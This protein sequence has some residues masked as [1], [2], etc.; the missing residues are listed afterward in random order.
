MEADVDFDKR[1]DFF[2]G[3]LATNVEQDC[4]KKK[5]EKQASHTNA[6]K[7]A[8]LSNE[9]FDYIHIACCQRLFSLAW[10]NDLTYAQSEDISPPKELPV[11]CC[12]G[13]SCN[14]IEPDYIQRE[15]FINITTPT[16]TEV[17]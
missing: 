17:D 8:K 7:C 10:Y 11:L 1:A 12:H 6:A 9:I 2:L 3:V 4:S 15:S 13:P 5:K 14:S 16:T